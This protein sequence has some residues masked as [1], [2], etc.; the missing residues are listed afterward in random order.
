[1]SILTKIIS[2]TAIETGTNSE[3]GMTRMQDPKNEGSIFPEN[4]FLE[5]FF[6]LLQRFICISV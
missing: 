5:K 2:E 6:S 3:T 4:K 1:M